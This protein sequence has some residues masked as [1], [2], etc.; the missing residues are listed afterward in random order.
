MLKD[1]CLVGG[2]RYGEETK[3]ETERQTDTR[4]EGQRDGRTTEDVEGLR[5]RS[6]VYVAVC[7]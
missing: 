4:T 2:I 5:R 3:G 7:D 1:G 6:G